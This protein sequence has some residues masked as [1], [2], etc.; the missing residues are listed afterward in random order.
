M[1]SLKNN[2]EDI[3]LLDGLC[4]I[5]SCQEKAV[6]VFETQDKIINVCQ[7]HFEILDRSFTLW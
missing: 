7:V 4:A 5:S 6:G 2:P 1:L 3:D